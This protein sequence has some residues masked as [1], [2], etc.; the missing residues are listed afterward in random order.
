[1]R[2]T[3]LG[4]PLSRKLATLLGGTLEASSTPGGGSTFSL[5]LPRTS[6][7]TDARVRP[8]GDSILII[9]D[10]EASRYITRQMFRGSKYRIIEARSGPEGTERARFEHPCLILLDLM[11]PYQNGFNVLDE[12]QADEETRDIPVVIETSKTLTEIDHERLASRQAAILPKAGSGRLQAL[13]TIQ[14]ILGEPDL[15]REEP[16]FMNSE[17]K[18]L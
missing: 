4:L 8:R 9:D 6:Y 15:F 11:M 16:E 5:T 14:R 10:E 12:L 17:Q 7:S 1:V 3:G 2:G 13:M 18:V